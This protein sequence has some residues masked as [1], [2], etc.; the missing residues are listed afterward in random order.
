MITAKAFLKKYT[1]VPNTFIDELFEFYNENTSPYD[2]V[3]NLD[4]IAKWLKTIKPQ[5][6]KTLRTSYKKDI[7]YTIE[8]APNPNKIDNRNNNYKKVLLTPDCFKRLS[9]Q[10]RS[11]KADEVRSYFVEIEHVLMKYRNDLVNGLETRIK[12]LEVNQK[13]KRN[14]AAK[15]GFIYILRASDQKDSVY[16]IG[17]T[18]NLRNRLANYN[19]GRAD[20]IEVLF[21]YETDDVDSVEACVKGLLKQNK[22]RKYKEVYQADI[23]MI[24]DF[25]KG[26]VQLKMRYRSPKPSV[27]NGGYYIGVVV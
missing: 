24:K 20:D 5:L 27:L 25:I 2:P 15:Q 9:M 8:K 26:C 23:N 4:Y 18:M 11:K 1:T 22:Y 10:S 12:D 16:K 6:I 17:R 3:I 21:T 13:P 19:S 7:D 14:V